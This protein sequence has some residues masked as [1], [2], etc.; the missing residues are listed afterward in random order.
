[1]T[2]PHKRLATTLDWI[3]ALEDAYANPDR[4]RAA[5]M[6][7]DAAADVHRVITETGATNVGYGWTGGKDSLALQAVMHHAG[8]AH[9]V[10]VVTHL[11][12][13]AVDAWLRVHTPDGVELQRQPFD[14]A[15]LAQREERWCLPYTKKDA[16]LWYEAVNW[17]GQRQW[18]ERVE[19]DLFLNGRR[20]SDGNHL[21]RNGMQTTR[22]TSG[23]IKYAP[24]RDWSHED[25]LNVI[26]CA[27][28]QLPP[29]YVMPRGWLVGSGCW[30]KRRAIQNG[31]E[32][33]KTATWQEV[34]DADPDVVREA[35]PL[36]VGARR[37]LTALQ[38]ETP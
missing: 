17:R 18:C 32:H 28:L 9:G 29:Y 1:M 14:L 25:V 33:D 3:D 27:G 23:T 35:A 4:K 36:I 37:Y 6:I 15:W 30:A 8:I 26:V 20:R 22:Y 13:P 19:C 10:A 38:G 34:W 5:R 12:Y 11:E 7:G 24:I 31:D 16:Y 2:V 21:G